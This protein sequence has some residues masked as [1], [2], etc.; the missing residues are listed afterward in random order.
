MFDHPLDRQT[1][2]SERPLQGQNHLFLSFHGRKWTNFRAWYPSGQCLD[3]ECSLVP[4]IKYKYHANLRQDSPYTFFGQGAIICLCKVIQIFSQTKLI[5]RTFRQSTAQS[6]DKYIHFG[7]MHLQTIQSRGYGS[8]V[9][10]FLLLSFSS[11]WI[12]TRYASL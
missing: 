10:L 1:R 9:K 2:V 7:T 11:F 5:D 12:K 6:V 4:S 3:H 8:N